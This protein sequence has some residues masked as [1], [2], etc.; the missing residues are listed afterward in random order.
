MSRDSDSILANLRITF[1]DGSEQVVPVTKTAFNLGRVPDN[2]L[3]LA[4]QRVSRQHARLLLEG[5]RIQ[6]IDLNS[7]NG[8]FVGETRLTPNVP[9]PIS[10]GQAFRIEPFT[11]RLEAVPSAAPAQYAVPPATPVQDAQSIT[12]KAVQVGMMELAPPPVPPKAPPSGSGQLPY[13][14]AFGLPRDASRYLKYLPP[15]YHEDEFLGQFLLAFEGIWTPIE[16]MIDHFD[17]YLDP[18]TTPAF[19]LEHLASW[20]DLTLDEKWSLGKRRALVAEAAEL[21]WRRGTRWSLSRHLEIYTGIMPE[22][23][24]PEDRPHHFQ[25]VLRV[26]SG[27]AVDRAVVER[28]IRANQPAHTTYKLEIVLV[29]ET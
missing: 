19:F 25:V 12:P 15:I 8:T 29:R 11:L 6:L 22:I 1:P 21:Y 3:P 24:E 7:R 28:I 26:P 2:D 9:F 27:Q 23:I 10:Y 16:Q 5:D 4:H 13:D 14:E 17:L 18:H 20:L